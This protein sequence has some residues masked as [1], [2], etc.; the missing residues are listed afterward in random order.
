MGEYIPGLVPGLVQRSDM[1]ALEITQP[2]GASFSLDGNE[3]RWQNW[4]MRLG[5]THRAGLGYPPVGYRTATNSGRR[6]PAVVRRDG[7]P[8]PRSGPDHHRRTAFDIGEW[9]LG[10][11]TTSLELGCD[12]LGEITYVDAVLHDSNGEPTTIRNAICLHEEDDGV[13]WSTSTRRPGPRSAGRGGW[14]SRSTRPWRTTST[15][16]TGASTR[17][18]RSSARSGPPGSWSPARSTASPRR[19]HRGGR[20]TYAPFH[21]HFIVAR[22]DMEV[23]G[24]ENT[25]VVSESE[26]CR[27]PRTI[28][29]AWRWCN[30]AGRC[31]PSPREGRTATSPA[32]VA[33][34]S[35]TAAASTGWD[36]RP[37]TSWS[38]RRPSRPWSPGVAYGARRG[39]R[40]HALGHALRRGRAVAAGEFCNQSRGS[41]GLPEWTAADRSIADTDIVLWHVFGIHHIPPPED[42][43]VMPVTRSRSR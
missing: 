30:A 12:C 6:A 11:M 29:T 13:L 42:W 19:R 3:L 7:R 25:V 35:S 2:D 43:P 8:L 9:G 16:S 40:P 1:Q 18:A 17:T 5:F 41:T 37:A 34:R 32:S 28:P 24:P 36:A 23:D 27:S 20:A 4:S 33:G 38:P 26:A 31:S 15:S 21:Q 22:M 14:S 39:H 10:F